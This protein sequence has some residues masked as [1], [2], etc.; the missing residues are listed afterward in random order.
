MRGAAARTDGRMLAS[1]VMRFRSGTP[2]FVGAL[3]ARNARSV[4]SIL[5]AAGMRI[6]EPEQTAA[7]A[8]ALHAN[9]ITFAWQLEQL[10]SGDWD[11]LNVSISLKVAVKAELANP[12]H[13]LA[14]S[15]DAEEMPD[16]L[17]RFLLMPVPGYLEP[18]PMNQLSAPF[19]SILISA[20]AD[21]QHLVIVLCEMLALASG[22][23]L[24]IPMG[25]RRGRAEA[26]PAILY[27]L[28]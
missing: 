14:T 3:P 22:L 27:L 1:H 25:M 26:A 4:D 28:L 8:S 2:P 18:Q 11:K 10:D 21:R 9:R 19:L 20:P 12:S 6:N 5:E 7:F 16:W 13:A 24:T 23:F 17:R 15:P